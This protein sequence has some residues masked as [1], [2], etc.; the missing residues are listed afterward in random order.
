MD[1]RMGK[2]GDG[3]GRGRDL[4]YGTNLSG[5]NLQIDPLVAQPEV[6]PI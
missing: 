3:G 4:D 5:G 6:V 1:Q 2:G